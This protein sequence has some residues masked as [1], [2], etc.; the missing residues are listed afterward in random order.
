MFGIEMMSIEMVVYF[1]IC[2]HRNG[3]HTTISILNTHHL[4]TKHDLSS[5]LQT[6]KA[7]E[8]LQELFG[9]SGRDSNPRPPA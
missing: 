4:N 9:R 6:K 8:F 1:L 2:K 3:K 5:Y 7:L